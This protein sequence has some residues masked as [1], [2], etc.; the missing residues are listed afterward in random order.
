MEKLVIQTQRLTLR[1]I[2]LNDL[3]EIHRLHILPETDEFNALGIP[4]DLDETK[5]VITPWVTA[6][7]QKEVSNYTFAILHQKTGGFMGLFGLRLGAKKYKRAEIWY[8]FHKDEWGNGYA[9]EAVKAV[10]N[11]GFN[12]LKLHRIE[13]GCAVDNIGSAKVLEKSGM[14]KEGLKGRFYL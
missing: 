6:N 2:T 12:T 5:G 4:K 13:A 9:T 11:Y 1:P 14:I 10:L 7:N 3:N 8:K